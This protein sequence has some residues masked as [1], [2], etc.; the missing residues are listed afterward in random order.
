M[1]SLE[2]MGEGSA[3]GSVA[4]LL[5][6]LGCGDICDLSCCSSGFGLGFCTISSSESEPSEYP[7]KLTRHTAAAASSP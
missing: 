2:C 6:V 5:A 7:S 4:I 1:T 3:R